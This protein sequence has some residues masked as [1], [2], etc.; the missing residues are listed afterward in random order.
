MANRFAPKS[1]RNNGQE[2]LPTGYSS[3]EKPDIVIAPVGI[4]DVDVAMFNLFDKELPIQ[5]GSS[6]GTD[7]KKVPVI[8]AGGEK[9]AQL[10]RNK[11][12]RD[13]VNSL[14]LP[15]ITIGRS[16]IQQSTS[17]DIVGRGMNQ[18][19]GEF[20]I[21]RR[22]SKSDRQ[23]QKI[24]NRLNLESQMDVAL[25]DRPDP[26]LLTLAPIGDLSSNADVV[27][28]ALLHPN[29]QKNIIETIVVP[30]PQ[31]FTATYEIILWTQYTH[32]MNQIM[33]ILMSS[34]LPQVQGWRLDTPKGYWFVAEVEEGSISPETNFDDMTQGERL[35]KQKFNVK[36]PAYIFAS[37][38]PGVPVPVKR[39]LS[40]PK[41]VFETGTSQNQSFYDNP[42]PADP[43]IVNGFFLGA[44]DPTLPLEH[45]D[46]RREDARRSGAGD[47]NFNPAQ[48]NQSDPALQSMPRGR[49]LERYAKVTS[50]GVDGKQMTKHVKVKNVNKSTGETIYG[51]GFDMNN[52][53]EAKVQE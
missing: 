31:F 25:N 19:S 3:G 44:D 45:R 30:S 7:L 49:S 14:I 40:A 17:E 43:L 42:S 35:I 38:A 29:K 8:F 39:Y 23:Y 18:R 46:V 47:L 52:L 28:G 1:K 6:D 34:Y 13:K 36:V 5:V 11:P 16:G 53:I 22:L 15:L 33:E 12:L 9:W 41:I 21:R 24:I 2:P 27:D 51:S 37:N 48:P 10:K 32:H 50:V 26:G 4:E 20:M